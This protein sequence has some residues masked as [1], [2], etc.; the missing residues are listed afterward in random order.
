MSE[1]VAKRAAELIATCAE[2]A[3]IVAVHNVAPPGIPDAWTD[4]NASAV[5][6]MQLEAFALTANG[7]RELAGHFDEAA[8]GRRD[9][10]ALANEVRE[11]IRILAKVVNDAEAHAQTFATTRHN[12]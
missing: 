8:A 1:V 3:P 7:L 4:L 5:I 11:R 9:I 12:A 2:D 6:A 10:P